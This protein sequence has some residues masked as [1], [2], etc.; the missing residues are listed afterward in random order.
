MEIQIDRHEIYDK[1]KV[2]DILVFSKLGHM[3]GYDDYPRE[4]TFDIDGS[5]E[6]MK[7]FA[8]ALAVLTADPTKLIFID[9]DGSSSDLLSELRASAHNRK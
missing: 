5:A 8:I 9:K 1:Q 6:E 3:W 4:S 7:R 2:H